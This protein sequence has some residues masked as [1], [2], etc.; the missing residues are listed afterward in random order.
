[1]CGVIDDTRL[2]LRLHYS[3]KQKKINSLMNPPLFENLQVIFEV[4][5]SPKCLSV[6]IPTAS[7]GAI[8]DNI[9]W[10][11]YYYIIYI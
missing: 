1:M 9:H 6:T 3:L 4:I 7:F 5:E 10:I 11:F 2:L 8:C